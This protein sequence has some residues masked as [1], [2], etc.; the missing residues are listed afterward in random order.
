MCWGTAH[1]GSLGG[2]SQLVMLP[3]GEARS[4][5]G[6]GHQQDLVLHLG[7]HDRRLLLWLLVDR[8]TINR[9]S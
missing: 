8:A 9:L 7:E 4:G 2:R 6:R 5:C 1:T 3:P